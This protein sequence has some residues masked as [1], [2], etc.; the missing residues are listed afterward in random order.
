MRL[1]GLLLEAEGFAAAK[2]WRA[3]VGERWCLQ[4]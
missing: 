1:L 3:G 2:G 4:V